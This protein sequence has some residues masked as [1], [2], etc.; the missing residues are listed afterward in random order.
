MP[1]DLYPLRKFQDQIG[2]NFRIEF[3]DGVV[4]LVLE[5]VTP[6]PAPRQLGASGES[7]PLTN[8]PARMEPF[9][10]LFRGPS[11]IRLPQRTYSMRN[12][13]FPAAIDVFIVPVGI[14]AEGSL[15]QAIFN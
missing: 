2:G 4:D 14:E 1:E 11:G 6:L 13:A 7:R 8:I 3:V 15:Y 12:E 10:L 9:T 5:S